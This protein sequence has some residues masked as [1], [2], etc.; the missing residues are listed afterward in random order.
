MKMGRAAAR[1]NVPKQPR[2]IRIGPHSRGV[3]TKMH[4]TGGVS[5]DDNKGIT[6]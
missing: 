6:M 4:N 1:R 5:G 3:C 2:V